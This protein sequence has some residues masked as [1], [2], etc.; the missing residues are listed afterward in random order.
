MLLKDKIAWISGGSSGI[1]RAIAKRFLME[2]A[3]V[4]LVDQNS[5]SGQKTASKYKKLGAIAFFKADVGNEKEVAHSMLMTKKQFGG[6]DIVVNNAGIWHTQPIRKLEEKKFDELFR[7]N[8]KGVLWG[9]KHA[10]AYLRRKGKR[11]RVGGRSVILNTASLAGF[12]AEQGWTAYDISKAGV[13]MATRVAALEYGAAG[14]RVNAIAP[15][16][17][18]TPLVLGHPMPKILPADPWIRSL[19]IPR[20]G[21]PEDV[22]SLAAFLCSD[23]ADYITGAVYTIDGG[24][25]S[26][27]L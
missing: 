26:G 12:M 4:A 5:S 7:V 18:A 8:T 14:I 6:I 9:M 24:A 22:A 10:Y 21:T 20:Y 13:I 2:G 19:P 1:G 15:G 17:I 25:T 3:S 23:Q 11:G 16:A 27:W